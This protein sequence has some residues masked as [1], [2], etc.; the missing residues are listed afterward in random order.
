MN[1]QRSTFYYFDDLASL[2]DNENTWANL[3][4]CTQQEG[5]SVVDYGTRVHELA[6][7]LIDLDPALLECLVFHR[8]KAG[9]R[10]PI[11]DMLNSSTLQPNS[12]AML[13][14]VVIAIERKLQPAN[15]GF[16][17]NQ[18]TPQLTPT[19]NGHIVHQFQEHTNDVPTMQS[20][21]DRSANAD[22]INE[23]RQ[24]QP[25]PHD[26]TTRQQP[27]GDEYRACQASPTNNQS[28]PGAFQIRGLHQNR[29]PIRAQEFQQQSTPDSTEATR[30]SPSSIPN[31]EAAPMLGRHEVQ[32]A[33]NPFKGLKRPGSDGGSFQD[34]GNNQ[35]VRK[36]AVPWHEGQRRKQQGPPECFYCHQLGHYKNTCPT[37]PQ[38]F[39]RAQ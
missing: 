2:Q 20:S 32:H 9:L 38:N 16:A 19:P 35:S 7:G 17:I 10:K 24:E 6:L 4:A 21:G 28:D 23:Q 11:K 18:L 13:D 30:Y 29:Q 34:D 8:V 25:W 1:G 27:S 3:F 36:K 26:T 22:W 15:K 31:D 37:N 33:A 5:E 39:S 14:Q 12:H